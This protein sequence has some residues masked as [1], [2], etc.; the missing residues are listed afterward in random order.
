M[1][2]SLVSYAAELT[3]RLENPPPTGNVAFLLFDSANAF[4]DLRDPAK[5]VKLPLDGREVYRLEN[6][7]PSEYALVVYF[8]ENNNDRIDKSFIGIPREPLGFSNRYRPK[9]PPSYSRAA[10]VL[11]EGESRHFDVELYRPLGKFG[12]LGIGP[13]II[14]RSSPYRDYDGGVYQVIPAIT[15]SG[16][17]LQIYGPNASFGLFGSGKLRIA[18]TG[19]Y[20]LG[21]YE[22]NESDFLEGMGDRKD[23]FMAGFA[24]LAEIPGGIDI[25]ASYEHDVLDRIGGGAARLEFDKSFQFSV[26]RFSPQIAFNW[27]SSKLSNHDFGVPN[28][29]ATPERPAY[30]VSDT[31]SVEGGLG[32]LI[33][34]TRNWLVVVNASVEFMDD[35][36][37][38]SPIVSKDYVI[39]GFGA[40][41]YVF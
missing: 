13:G 28:S 17:R 29:K 5:V 34:I 41:N 18:A 16:E 8:D 33:E 3:V 36:V 24:L 12:R 38:D 37:T 1:G 11:A 25:S 19:K 23:T 21:V 39:K 31:F 4:G 9:G 14:A 20:R 7:P 30:D 15:Y 22:E 35:E 27:Q 6:V 40:I 2:W 10:F 32:M 26:F